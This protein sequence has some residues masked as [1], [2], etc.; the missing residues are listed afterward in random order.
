M[1]VWLG[2]ISYSKTSWSVP[3]QKIYLLK[4][5]LHESF[6]YQGPLPSMS[7]LTVGPDKDIRTYMFCMK[8]VGIG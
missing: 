1:S 7:L 8:D 3:R 5:S 4:P 2:K 6:D